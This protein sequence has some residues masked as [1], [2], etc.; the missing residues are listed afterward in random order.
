MAAASLTLSGCIFLPAVVSSPSPT[1]PD[2]DGFDSTEGVDEGLES[3]YAQEVDWQNCG[4]GQRCAVIT[5]PMDWFNP[6]PDK[7][8]EVHMVVNEAQGG[9]AI[10]DLLYNPGGPGASGYDYVQQF[11]EYLVPPEILEQYNLV[12]FDPR[13]VSRS[14]PITCYDDPSTLYERVFTVGDSEDYEGVDWLSDEGLDISREASRE[15]S[16]ACETYTGEAIGYYGT[17]QAASDMDLMRALLGNDKLDYYGVSYGTLLGAT[18]AGLFP[19][20]VGRFVLDAATDPTAGGVESTLFQA[21]GFELAMGNFLEVCMGESDCPIDADDRQEALDEM[22]ELFDEL[23]DDPISGSNDRYLTSGS[24]FI[25]V[26]ANLYAEFQWPTLKTIIADV[27]NGEPESALSAVEGYYGV[28]PDGTFADN[29]YE[30]LIGIN[31]LDN[32]PE[33]DYDTVRAD[34]E[35]IQDEA[36]TVGRFFVGLSSCLDWPNAGSRSLDPITAP[37]ADPIIVIGGL[38]DP[39]THYDESVALADMLE[40]GILITVADEGHGQYGNGN[41]CV[42]EPV[43][44]YLLNGNAPSGDIDNC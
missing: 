32:V 17:E 7:T 3:F 29:S 2:D 33:D 30:A 18:Y 34:A 13:G 21:R 42:D 8:V 27:Q 43:N 20:N 39:A 4:D 19:D 11:A 15:F 1:D 9:N 24:F 37:G 12:G 16:E 36:P 31:C 35:R 38:N 44:D 25:A 40:S 41:M 10:G 22:T 6:D 5:A 28:N 14:S 23:D 26:A